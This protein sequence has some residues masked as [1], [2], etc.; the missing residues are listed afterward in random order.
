MNANNSNDQTILWVGTANGLNKLIINDELKNLQMLRPDVEI[1]SYTVDD[2]L[3]DNSVESILED[4]YGN[5][6]IGTSSGISSRRC[7]RGGR[8]IVTPFKR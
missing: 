3:S 7:L 4:E 1:T 6:W 5:L 8:V 2:G